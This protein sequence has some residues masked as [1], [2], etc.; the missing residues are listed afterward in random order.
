M[1][2]RVGFELTTK[3]LQNEPD[4]E[5]DEGTLNTETK[6]ESVQKQKLSLRDHSATGGRRSNLN[7]SI[8]R[9][10]F[11]LKGLNNIELKCSKLRPFGHWVL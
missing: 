1:V 2:E 9:M 6:S 3:A 5:G 10:T 8:S 7:F 4:N 11:I